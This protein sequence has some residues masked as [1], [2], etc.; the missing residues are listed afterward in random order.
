ML[1]VLC[2]LPL[3]LSIPAAPVAIRRARIFLAFSAEVR[4]GFLPLFYRVVVVVLLRS[5]SPTPGAD[6]LRDCDCGRRNLYFTIL[7]IVWCPRTVHLAK[8]RLHLLKLIEILLRRVRQ[9]EGRLWSIWYE[10]RRR[11]KA[12]L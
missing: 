6:M 3:L 2:L 9:D 4:L 5:N 8:V 12:L 11:G 1:L 10:T 7:R